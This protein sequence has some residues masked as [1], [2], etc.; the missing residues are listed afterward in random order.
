MQFIKN[1]SFLN[2]GI[3]LTT[4]LLPFSFALNPSFNIDLS[5]IRVLIPI[6]FLGWLFSS[7]FKKNLIIDTRLR[8]WLLIFI[9]LFSLISLF[10]SVNSFKAWRKILFLASIFP[11]YW[12]MF[13]FLKNKKNTILI[14]KNIFISAFFSALIGLAQFFSQ[15]VFGLKTVF[16]FQSQLIPFFLGKTFSQVVLE[17]NSWLVNLEGITIFRALGFFPDP[18]LFSLFLNISFFIGCYLFFKNR[19]YYFLIGSFIILITSLL[20]FSR[21]GYLSLVLTFIF[22]WLI[23]LKKKFLQNSIFQKHLIKINF[24]LLSLIVLFFTI[25]NP[26]NQ[27][28]FSIFNFQ[29]NSINERLALWKTGTTITQN[30]FFTGV[31]IGNL[32]EEIIPFSNQRVPIYAHNLFLDFSSELGFFGGLAVFFII[33]APIVQFF[34]KPT[35]QNLLVATIFFAIFI[36]SMFETP[37][38]STQLLPLI[39]ILLAL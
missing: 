19:S 29:E 27:R 8:S 9:L 22:F 17:Y 23:L 33:I 3:L 5:I 10:W 1:F 24:L 12:V 6:L 30:N 14:L 16:N 11:F 34:K 21:S 38:Y 37:F 36:Q 32:S 18:H 15:F 39:L 26:I 35:N 28:F 25:P 4:A 20:T 31:G 7:L 2:L 13:I